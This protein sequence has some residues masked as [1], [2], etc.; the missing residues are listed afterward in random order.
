MIELK[1]VSKK[2]TGKYVL[3]NVNIKVNDG[4]FVGLKGPRGKG[5]T[6]ILNIISLQEK[7][8]GQLIINGIEISRKDK[9]Q[10]RKLL[11]NEIGYLFQ[12]FALVDDLSVYENLKMIMNGNK[13]NMRTMM[14]DK[15]EKVGLSKE[16]L[17]RKVCSCSGGEQQRI[18]IARIM[19]KKCSIVLADEPTGSLDSENANLVVQLLKNLQKEGKTIVMVSHSDE[20]LLACDRVIEL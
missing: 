16:I 9:K 11:K 3:E 12:N 20:V 14:E 15:L 19:L 8:E 2:Y 6:T 5:K 4:E 18:A 17:D 7:Y 1:N 10:C 13:K